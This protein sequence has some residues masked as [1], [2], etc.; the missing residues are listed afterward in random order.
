MT[1]KIR[2]DQEKKLARGFVKYE[3][4]ML[5]AGVEAKLKHLRLSKENRDRFIGSVYTD[6]ILLHVRNLYEFLIY[7]P[8]KD[9]IRAIDFLKNKSWE[10]SE[11]N[12][13]NKALIEVINKY[14]SHPSYSRKM[15]EEKPKWKIKEMRDEIN[16]AYQEFIEE[17]PVPERSHW[18]IQSKKS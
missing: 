14:R 7:T 16:A 11:L 15:G 18:K 2:S 9:S 8:Y 12:L 17:L 3:L 13:V 4:K 1:R 10:S 6:S 5:N